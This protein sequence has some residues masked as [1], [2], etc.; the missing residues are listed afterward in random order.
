MLQDHIV[1]KVKSS[2]S[3]QKNPELFVYPNPF[4]ESVNL[5]FEEVG[6]YTLRLVDTKGQVVQEKRLNAD[7]NAMFTLE[8]NAPKGYYLLQVIRKNSLLSSLQLIKK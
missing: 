2:L 1:I 3:A 5:R 7:E 4:V 8:V 6:A